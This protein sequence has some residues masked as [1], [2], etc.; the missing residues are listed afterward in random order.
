[1][2][3]LVRIAAVVLLAAAAYYI[4]G[5]AGVLIAAALGFGGVESLVLMSTVGILVVAGL[6]WGV[7]TLR[8]KYR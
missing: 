3:V 4:L 8:K 2:K 6:T 5:T 1:M 7:L